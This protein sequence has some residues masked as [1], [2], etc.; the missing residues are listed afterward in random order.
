M[1][2]VK[3]AVRVRPFNNREISRECKCIIQMSGNTTG[4]SYDLTSKFTNTNINSK[5][6]YF[7]IKGIFSY[8]YSFNF[9]LSQTQ[10]Q[11]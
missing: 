4:A 3:V 7:D 11:K 6:F 1:S 5:D 10:R 9:Q 2:S 8:K